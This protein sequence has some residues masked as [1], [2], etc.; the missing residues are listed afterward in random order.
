MLATLFIPATRQFLLPAMIDTRCRVLETEKE[1]TERARDV[2]SEVYANDAA[3]M[4]EETILFFENL[5]KDVMDHC[6]HLH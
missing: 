2:E 5:M 3:V 1:A 6:N 4:V